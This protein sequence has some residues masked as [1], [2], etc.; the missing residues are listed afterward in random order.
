MAPLQNMRDLCGEG[1]ET[2]PVLF[3]KGW[4]REVLN[5]A[6]HDGTMIIADVTFYPIGKGVSAGD[7][8]RGAVNVLCSNAIGCYPNSM[9][10]VLEAQSIDEIFSSIKKAEQYIIDSGFQRV[11]TIIK[12]DHRTDKENSVVHK[13]QRIG[14]DTHVK[15][16]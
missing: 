1:R 16:Q 6:R 13:L 9:A 10:T 11:E 3:E 2:M 7:I 12:I 15:E 14:T 5:H 8:I 4:R